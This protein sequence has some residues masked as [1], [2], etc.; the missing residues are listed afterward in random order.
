M[1]K[2]VIVILIVSILCVGCNLSSNDNDVI[3]G[4]QTVIDS[5]DNQANDYSDGNTPLSYT[6]DSNPNIEWMSEITMTSETSLVEKPLNITEDEYYVISSDLW[7]GQYNTITIINRDGK[8]IRTFYDVLGTY[9]NYGKINRNTPLIIGIS[10]Y[11][12]KDEK[13]FE[14]N[15]QYGMYLPATDSFIVEPQYDYITPYT[16]NLY[17]GAKD[18]NIYLFDR[19]GKIL[20]TI[21]NSSK[22]YIQLV[23][24]FIWLFDYST[25]DCYVYNLDF[26][27]IKAFDGSI[28]MCYSYGGNY[29]LFEPKTEVNKSL[30]L[31]DPTGEPIVSENILKEKGILP[32]GEDADI[33]SIDYVID[34]GLIRFNYGIYE[35]LIDKDFNVIDRINTFENPGHYFISDHFEYYEY[36]NTMKDSD[37]VLKDSNGNEILDDSGLSYHYSLGHNEVYRFDKNKLIVF[38]YKYNT[39]KEFSLN[40]YKD[41]YVISP[42]EDVYIIRNCVKPYQITAYY[43]DKQIFQKDNYMWSYLYYG[44]EEVQYQILYP[45]SDSVGMD[46]AVKNTI[47][48]NKGEI[49]YTSPTKES[50]FSID[51]NYLLVK[52]GNYTGLV[53]FNGNFVFKLLDSDLGDD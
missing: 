41:P 34:T 33:T 37:I 21:K 10:T 18:N 29:V 1:K 25:G 53:D 52:R 7:S 42:F 13:A 23:G 47:I 14:S 28:G 43:K 6:K 24:D 19:T 50:I 5:T 48:N 31:L 16:D 2:I 22:H 45:Y 9:V 20:H 30:E 51:D 12:K 11:E 44:I 15:Y 27:Q 39:K 46:V 38:N 36:S 8:I 26:E 17:G 35:F 32:I 49:V 3:A 40:G 4:E